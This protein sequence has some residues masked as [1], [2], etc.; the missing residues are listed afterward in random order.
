MMR[1]SLLLLVL[2]IIF[3]SAAGY[4]QVMRLLPVKAERGKTAESQPLP[5]IKIG[6]RILRL[7][8]GGLIFDQQNRTIL[9]QHLPGNAEVLFTRDQAGDIQR[10]YLLSDQEIVRVQQAGTR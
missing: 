6:S 8:P 3:G 9:Q 5:L 4:A 7:A 10:L 2:C 1:K